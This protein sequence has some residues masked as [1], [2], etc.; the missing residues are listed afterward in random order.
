MKTAFFTLKLAVGTLLV[1]L[2][3]YLVLVS[4][5]VGEFVP[6][7]PESP[8]LPIAAFIMLGRYAGYRLTDGRDLIGPGQSAT[9]A[10]RSAA[11]CL[12]RTNW[13]TPAFSA[14]IIGNLA[15]IVRKAIPRACTRRST[16]KSLRRKSA[17]P[18]ASRYRKPT[19]SFAATATCGGSARSIGDRSEFVVKPACGRR[20]RDRRHRR[21][22]RERLSNLQRPRNQRRRTRLSS[23]R[24]FFPVCIPSV[25]RSITR[26]SSTESSCTRSSNG[27]RWAARPCPRHSTRRA[28][29]AISTGCHDSIRRPGRYQHQGAVA[30]AD[31]SLPA[32]LT[33]RRVQQPGD[34]ASQYG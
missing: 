6:T 10:Q 12:G 8:L 25:G 34:R 33:R 9:A 21:A 29:T 7:Y 28:V 4:E 14:S 5:E 31:T 19:P 11:V 23:A 15:F 2:L 3:C 24:R 20:P 17:T 27:S 30:A 13:K 16:T 22:K 1:A 18:T 32:P 26:S